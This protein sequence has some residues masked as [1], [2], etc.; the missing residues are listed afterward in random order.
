VDDG[1]RVGLLLPQ[2]PIALQADAT[3]LKQVF[4]NLL[5]NA[6][7][8]SGAGETIWIRGVT[9]SDEAV[10]ELFSQGQDS[11][12]NAGL[13][14]GLPLVKEYVQLH[15]G[16]VQARSEGSGRGSEFIVRLPLPPSG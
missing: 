16:S 1:P 12:G 14:L 8:F 9:E 5:S 7:K 13:G 10:F 4:V 11:G 3:R 2:T 6:S 15:G